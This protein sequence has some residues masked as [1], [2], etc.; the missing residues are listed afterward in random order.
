MQT[1]EDCFKNRGKRC[2]H[3]FYTGW[4]PSHECEHYEKRRPKKGTVTKA[5]ASGIGLMR[6]VSGKRVT[7]R[8]RLEHILEITGTPESAVCAPIEEAEM[9]LSV[10]YAAGFKMR[11]LGTLLTPEAGHRFRYFERRRAES[12]DHLELVEAG[13]EVWR[14]VKDVLAFRRARP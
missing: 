11:I 7:M 5:P 13:A 8:R 10:L 1:E 6:P 3:G 9:I 2:S 12:K 4:C 14:R